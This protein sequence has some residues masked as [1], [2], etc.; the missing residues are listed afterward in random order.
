MSSIDVVVKRTHGIKTFSDLGKL[1]EA[2]KMS[3]EQF[4]FYREIFVSSK[5]LVLI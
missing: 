2:Q 5:F 4:I 1:R 3:F